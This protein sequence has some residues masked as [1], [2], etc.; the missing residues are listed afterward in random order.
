[1]KILH[2]VTAGF[3]VLCSCTAREKEPPV[4]VDRGVYEM[5]AHHVQSRMRL[6]LD[7]SAGAALVMKDGKVVY[8]EYFGRE[9]R[10]P[11]A[12]Q[13]TAESRFPFYS[14]S[15]GFASA[16]LLSLVSDRVISLDDPVSKYLDY[17]T[18]K[19]S[20]GKFLRD[21][22]IVRHLA[23]HTSGLAPDSYPPKPLP[24]TDD[25]LNFEPG[26]DF[27]YTELGMRVLGQV[28]KA[29]TGKPYQELIRERLLEPLDLK[30]V[31][32]LNKGENT[33]HL[34]ETCLGLNSSQMAYSG[35]YGPEI[36]PG[37]GLYG[38]VRDIGRYAQL[39]LDSGRAGDKVIFKEELIREAWQ[40]QPPGRKQGA[41]YG[42]LFW[43]FPQAEAVVFSGMAHSICAILP[44]EKMILV[45][46]LNQ[47]EDGR[48]WDFEAEKLS[49]ARIGRAIYE[50]AG[51]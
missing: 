21:K 30:S 42:I 16:V 20:G 28:M 45:M 18:G 32:Y 2:T 7:C 5:L 43:L 47:K 6:S 39:W 35:E 36:E 19:G 24:F 1:M 40:I 10:K 26:T 48:G 4:A 11:D 50:Q 41:E 49:L 51:R 22:V 15:K 34:V 25:T 27:L 8:E 38:T 12:P 9:S 37:S 13:V 23:S 3:L 33:A 31:G 29:A 14:V 46:G 44:R 17:F